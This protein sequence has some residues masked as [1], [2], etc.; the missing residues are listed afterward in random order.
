MSTNIFKVLFIT[1]FLSPQIINSQNNEH[2]TPDRSKVAAFPSADG[3]GKYTTGGAG[4][5]VYT[6]TS[7]ADDGSEGTFRWAIGKKGPRTIVFAVS[8]IIELQKP[9]RVNNG[10]VTIAGQ[11]A[12]GD[13][14]CLKNYTF[15]IQADNVI[16]RFIRSRMGVDI[17]QKGDDAMNGTKAHKNIIIDHCSL[18]GETADCPTF[19]DN[20]NF[21]LQC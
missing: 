4:G 12:P 6:V 15:S 10:D 3:A 2:P 11:T 18:S 21:P 14:I 9:L 19:Y 13:G 16:V 7:L 1:L 5:A 8:G 17:K 20:S